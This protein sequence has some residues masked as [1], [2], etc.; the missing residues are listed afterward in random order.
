MKL[1]WLIAIALL[2]IILLIELAL[3]LLYGFGNP[4]IYQADDAM[5]Y[6]LAPNQTVRRFGNR[7]AINAYSMRSDAI[8]IDRPDRTLRVFLLGDSVVNGGWWTDQSQTISA[9]LQS[10]MPGETVQNT[11]W[12]SIQV[13]NA[14]ANSWSPRSE[15]AYLKQ[16]GL[17]Q[18]HYLVL[19]INTDDLFATTPTP[20]G[21]GVDPNYPDRQPW[22]A[23]AEVVQRYL[24]PAPKPSDAL[25]AIQSEGG[26]RVG[27]NLAAIAQIQTEAKQ[28]GTQLLLI[29]TPLLREVKTPGPRDYEIDARQRLLAFTQAQT[30]DY[31]DVLP[32]FTA[33]TDP[34][35]LY[36][37]HI[38]LSPR[39]NQQ[40][41]DRIKEWLRQH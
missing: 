36:H 34:Q 15:L 27:A 7:I 22:G 10:Q 29:L 23:I 3:R 17:F 40:I 38:H 31:I 8:T 33:V 20:L 32:N 14:S 5:G 30:I 13:L 4:L 9:I 18:S 39:G 11:Q 24:L 16:F 41:S 1:V 2:L 26:D 37:D 35:S 6:R 21:V 12:Q 28:S 19:V 25:K